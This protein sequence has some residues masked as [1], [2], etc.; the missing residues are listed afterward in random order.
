MTNMNLISIIHIF[1]ITVLCLNKQQS[2][3]VSFIALAFFCGGKRLSMDDNSVVLFQH[4]AERG[5]E[6]D[7]QVAGHS[8]CGIAAAQ[9]F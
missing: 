2:N 7:T 5:F 1:S 9:V 6:S 8:L 3:Q 4:V